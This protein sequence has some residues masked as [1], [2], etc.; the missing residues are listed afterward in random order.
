MSYL[1]EQYL[2]SLHC[3]LDG[4]YRDLD[5]YESIG[6]QSRIDEVERVIAS[7]KKQIAEAA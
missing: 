3:A 4:C 5:Y 6:H 2:E 7:L 1:Q